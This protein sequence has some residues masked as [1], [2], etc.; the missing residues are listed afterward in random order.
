MVFTVNA[1]FDIALGKMERVQ[2]IFLI[3]SEY[4]DAEAFHGK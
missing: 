1:F 3:P 4:R 2:N